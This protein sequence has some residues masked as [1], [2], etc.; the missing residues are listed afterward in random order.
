[1]LLEIGNRLFGIKHKVHV[2][3]IHIKYA[4]LKRIIDGLRRAS[5]QSEHGSCRMKDDLVVLIKDVA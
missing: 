5:K 2:C 4:F 1:M 3:M